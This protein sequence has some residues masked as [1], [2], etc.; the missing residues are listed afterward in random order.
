L[1]DPDQYQSQVNETV[2]KVDFFPENFNVLSKILKKY[3]TFDT[4]ENGKTLYSSNA[5]TKSKKNSDFPT[6]VELGVG[7]KKIYT[8]L[9]LG[10]GIV[11]MPI[12][13]RIRVG[14]NMEIRV[15]I[16]NTATAV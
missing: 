12:R 2:D 14:I 7:T 10:I 8:G 3:D 11:L 15:R 4:E 16:H 9:E 5:V 1:P 13:I 6:C